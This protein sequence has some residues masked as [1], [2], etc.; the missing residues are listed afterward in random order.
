MANLKGGSFD[1]QLKDIH[2]RLS[3]FGVGRH[4]KSDHKTHSSALA[5]KRTEMSK[6]FANYCTD[7][8]FTGKLNEHM[9]NENIKDFLQERTANLATTTQENYARGF[10]SMVQGL[11]EANI[12]IDANKSVFNDRVAEIKENAQQAE[13]VTGRAIDNVEN[14]IQ[15]I[16]D[17]RYESGVIADVQNE[18]G[19]RVAEAHELVSNPQNYISNNEVNGLVGK[20]NHVYDSKTISPDLVAKISAVQDIP[21][22]RTYQN[23]LVKEGI[24][25][26]DFRFTYAN[27]HKDDM[28]RAEL[29]RELNHEREDMTNYYLARG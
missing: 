17:G 22:I 5:E 25:S 16:Y 4:G 19:L 13:I 18:L 27:E 26:H 3:A 11:K 6:S 28:T 12:D 8:G 2:H 9:T 15:N 21:T 10:D 29:S 23:D 20:G 24:N 14:V 1:K 7:K